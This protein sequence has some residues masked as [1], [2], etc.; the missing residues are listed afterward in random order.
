MPNTISGAGSFL[1][2]GSLSAPDRVYSI[3]DTGPGGGKV[4]YDAGSIL[5]WGRYIEVAPDTWSGGIDQMSFMFGIN[6]GISGTLDAIGTSVTNTDLLLVQSTSTLYIAKSARNYTGGG[7]TNWQAPSPGDLNLCWLHVALMGTLNAFAYDYLS[8]QEWS[9]STSFCNSQRMTDGL[10]IHTYK[11][12][13]TY[14]RPVRYFTN[15][16][17]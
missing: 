17:N 1:G 15:S 3:G 6:S 9:G 2:V 12:Q 11:G 7:K 13:A 14:M 16:T 8:S 4:I 5:S 10:A